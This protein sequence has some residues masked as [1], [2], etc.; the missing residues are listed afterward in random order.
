MMKD[1]LKN[2]SMRYEYL[3]RL[4]LTIFTILLV[5]V[6]MMTYALTRRS[7]EEINTQNNEYYVER[8]FNFTSMYKEQINHL[9]NVA[10]RVGLD[11]K[12]DKEIIGSH[13]W[14]RIET[15]E[16][17][18]D[19]KMA[20][21]MANYIG[22]CFY[23][24][25]YVFTSISSNSVNT[26][27]ELIAGDNTEMAEA[28]KKMLT[29]DNGERITI[30]SSFDTVLADDPAIIV[31]VP[32]STEFSYI[33]NAAVIYSLSTESFPQY[34]MGQLEAEP[35][36]LAIF[37]GQCK[38]FY[39]NSE[40][41]AALCDDERFLSFLSNAGEQYYEYRT[42]E[43]QSRIFRWYDSNTGLFF[44]SV[45]PEGIVMQR[46]R[47]F[48]GSVRL[49]V[50]FMLLGLV[51]LMAVT[52][53]INYKP[54]MSMVRRIR[55]MKVTGAAV[56][57]ISELKV[58]EAVLT[59]I[60]RENKEMSVTVSEQ[61]LMLMEY[62]LG[63]ILYGLPIQ[64]EK[65]GYLDSSLLDKFFMVVSVNELRLDN[66][67]REQLTGMIREQL[68]IT[69]Y[70]TDIQYEPVMV[71][72]CVFGEGASPDSIAS[73]VEDILRQMYHTDFITGAGGVV[74]NLN[75]IR[76]SY[77]ESRTSLDSLSK[78]LDKPGCSVNRHLERLMLEYVN[79]HFNQQD[80]SLVQ[81][82]DRF[83][84]SVYTCSRLFKEFTGIGFKEYISGKRMELSKEL[85]LSTNK[86]IYEIAAETGFENSSYFMTWFKC[87]SGMTPSHFRK[88]GVVQW[89]GREAEPEK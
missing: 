10:I 32:I 88:Y 69:A 43:G 11:G 36:G 15:V 17:M 13:P 5:P 85:L 82:S 66:S 73:G 80:I 53:Y 14:Q 3:L 89:L 62:I 75:D 35:Y 4:I 70:I 25:D 21:P 42:E 64:K 76:K 39:Y 56:D 72:I 79:H 86:N 78:I 51:L 48:Y 9:I 46:V 52:I 58:V 2:L 55:A 6:L 16:T 63:N 44:V 12:L 24:M 65:I 27:I 19:Y 60:Q 50:L 22:I 40:F 8:T 30:L 59:C 20:V 67:S 34:F 74:D 87:N 77:S 57:D 1:K 68:G 28:L 83:N 23:D 61:K 71:I 31:T 84:L 38:P 33:N 45:I 26:Y 7:Y 47:N 29:E 41:D 81:V 49:M 37:D 18:N 54:V